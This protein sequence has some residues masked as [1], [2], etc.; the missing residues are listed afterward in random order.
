[1]VHVIILLTLI[2]CLPALQVWIK[3]HPFFLF[4]SSFFSR[5]HHRFKPTLLYTFHFHKFLNFISINLD[6]FTPIFKIV[7]H[8]HMKPKQDADF[9][10]HHLV[11]YHNLAGNIMFVAV[12]LGAKNVV[13]FFLPN[14]LPF[15]YI[16]RK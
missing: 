1:M 3:T 14:F 13:A 5:N 11:S 6:K 9:H 15:I 10:S 2:T 4:H 8:I 12:E 7:S 16:F